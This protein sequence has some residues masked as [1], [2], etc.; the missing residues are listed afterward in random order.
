M[1]HLFGQF[2]SNALSLRLE[3]AAGIFDELRIHG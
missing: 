3:R 2:E 1:L